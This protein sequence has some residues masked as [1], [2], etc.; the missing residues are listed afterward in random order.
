MK[1]WLIAWGIVAFI[2]LS[3][4]GVVAVAMFLIVPGLILIAAPTVFL[5]SALFALFQRVMRIPPGWKLNAV[6]AVLSAFSGWAVAQP[7]AIVGHRAFIRADLPEVLPSSPIQL[8]GNVR[9]ET[10][11][12]SFSMGHQGEICAALCA[13]V[14]DTHGVASVA[15]AST[16]AAPDVTPLVYRLTPRCSDQKHDENPNRPENNLDTFPPWV[17]SDVPRNVQ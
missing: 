4:P 11:R 7:W 12:H 1:I 16:D 5:Y 13:A 15:V 2:A 6:A 10:P 9:L 17:P 3:A 8:G 14:L